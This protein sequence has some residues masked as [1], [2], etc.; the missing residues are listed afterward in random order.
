MSIVLQS[1]VRCKDLHSVPTGTMTSR[2]LRPI[3]RATCRTSISSA[4]REYCCIDLV[5]RPRD[6]IR[7]K[8]VSLPDSLGTCAHDYAIGIQFPCPYPM[9][10]DQA[11][12]T[13]IAPTVKCCAAYATPRYLPTSEAQIER[14]TDGVQWEMID[15]R[16]IEASLEVRPSCVRGSEA[17]SKPFGPYRRCG[18]TSGDL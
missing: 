6:L 8:E 14:W 17:T 15:M 3:V 11:P 10:C 16:R 12:T 18:G 5:S 1:A 9:Y 7:F 13:I 4:P 2:D